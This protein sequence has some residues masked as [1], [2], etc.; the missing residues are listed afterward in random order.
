VIA[1]KFL[2]AGRVGPFSGFRW[3]APGLW[4]HASDTVIPCREGIHACRVQDLPW[5]LAEELWEIELDGGVQPGEHK[6]IAHAGRLRSRVA[7]WTPE[8]ATE[9][10]EAC[11]WRARNHA[12][13][14]LRRGGHEEPAQAL[15][16]CESLE[17]LRQLARELAKQLPDTRIMLTVARGGAFRALTDAAPTSAYIAAHAAKRLDGP[18]SYD[19]ERAWQSRWLTARLGL[20]EGR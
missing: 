11:A 4:V 18:S 9:Y 19:T 8:C 17:Q 5:W 15:A 6:V 1:Y 16:T 3:P 10:G 20:R 14:A 12:M 13:E 2:R 7:A